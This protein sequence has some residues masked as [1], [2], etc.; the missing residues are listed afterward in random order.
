MLLAM[1]IGMAYY[2]EMMVRESEK[3]NDSFNKPGGVDLRNFPKTASLSC[4]VGQKP[5]WVTSYSG[6]PDRK[7]VMRIITDD[8]TAIATVK[9]KNDSLETFKYIDYKWVG[10]DKAVL[11]LLEEKYRKDLDKC[12]VLL[13][14]P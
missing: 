7:K 6:S 9:G 1:V 12:L 14:N 3:K 10:A 8:G 4:G 5:F 13:S 11:A 2:F